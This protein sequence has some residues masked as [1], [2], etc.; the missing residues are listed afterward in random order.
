M[1]EKQYERD[2]LYDKLKDISIMLAQTYSGNI[3]IQLDVS[4]NNRTAKIRITE[5]IA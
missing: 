3:Q 5:N 2:L 4:K 1:T